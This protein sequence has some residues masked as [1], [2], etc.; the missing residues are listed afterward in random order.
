M[1]YSIP[2]LLSLILVSA[3]CAH[4]Q[5]VGCSE[6]PGYHIKGRVIAPGEKFDRYHEL[7]QL[8]E[9]RLV[10]WAYTDSTGQFLFPEQ[11]AGH[12]YVVV[13][14]DG[15]KE[16]KERVR[17]EGCSAIIDHFVFMEFD[18]EAIR[19]V[20]LDFTGEVNEAVD[21]TELKRSFPKKAVDEFQRARAERLEGEA[22]RARVRLEKL[23][24]QYPDFYDARNALGSV[25]LEMKRF[26]DAETHYN[27]ARRLK[28]NSAAPLVSLGSL[29][30]QEAEMSLN[31]EPGI[32]GVVLPGGDLGI[33]LNDAREVLALA[34]KIKPDASFAYYLAGIAEMRGARFDK[35]EENLRKALEI[36]PKLRWARLGLGNLFIKQGKLKEA[37]AEYDAYLVDYKKVANRQEVER[38]RAKIALEMSKETK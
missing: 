14:M 13:R 12:Y 27:E 5:G 6:P 21:V 37:I 31:P 3:F 28:P 24:K 1:R 30:V 38:A 11:P 10:A 36:E 25:Y 8:D 22:D 19:P 15:F 33:I 35:S 17:V 9:S 32:V 16:Y 2:G 7:L 23:L 29:Y 20:I 4:A 18:D 26:R 34:I